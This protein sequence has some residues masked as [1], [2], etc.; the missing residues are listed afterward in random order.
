[1]SSPDLPIPGLSS[2]T[3]PLCKG[4]LPKEVQER[5]LQCLHCDTW[6]GML[7]GDIQVM[8][9]TRI[10]SDFERQSRHRRKKRMRDRALGIVPLPGKKTAFLSGAGFSWVLLSHVGIVFESLAWRDPYL[11]IEPFV[12]LTWVFFALT[13][14]VHLSALG[15]MGLGSLVLW[16][17]VARFTLSAE[18]SVASYQ[19]WVLAFAALVAAFWVK[20]ASKE[21]FRTTQLQLLAFPKQ[22]FLGMV[23][24]SPLYWLWISS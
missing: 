14:S 18:Q 1:M 11:T 12:T 16:E 13:V 17:L 9:S 3:C 22:I 7:N 10:E 20:V 24:G 8:T 2:L 4:A 19:F 21:A 15:A 6:V 23:V 5:A